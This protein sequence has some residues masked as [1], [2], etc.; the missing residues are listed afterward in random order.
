M[1]RCHR[2]ASEA[3][4]EEFADY[5]LSVCGAL[6]IGARLV[7]LRAEL[8]KPDLKSIGVARLLSK[9]CLNLTISSGGLA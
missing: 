2:G 7:D 8:V 9:A 3:G 6:S 4:L 1:W 5:D